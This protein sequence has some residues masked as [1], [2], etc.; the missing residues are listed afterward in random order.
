[1][2]NSNRSDS[3]AQIDVDDV[4]RRI[5]ETDRR[6]I[7][8][9]LGF[10]FE[11]ATNTADGFQKVLGP[12][13][14]GEGETPNFSVNLADG[15]FKDWGG[16]G[17]A[18]NL[19]HAVMEVERL[20]F[21]EAVAWV[22]DAI[23]MDTDASTYEGA[24]TGD[25]QP[26]APP[27]PPMPSKAST[28]VPQEDAEE[29]SPIEA[30]VSRSGGS[31]APLSAV[32]DRHNRLMEDEPAA[33]CAREYLMSRGIDRDTMQQAQLGLGKNRGSWQILVP[34]VDKL[35][36][37]P[38]VVAMKRLFFVPNR[39]RGGGDWERENGRKKMRN[40]GSAALIDH[41]PNPC[42]DGPVLVCEG[43]TDMLSALAHGFNAVAGTS[44]AGTF[45]KEWAAYIQKMQAADHGVIVAFD[46]DTAGRNGTPKAAQKLQ[47]QGIENVRI[48]RVPDGSDVND[49]VVKHGRSG[50]AALVDA[51]EPYAPDDPTDASTNADVSATEAAQ[52]PP[53]DEPMPYK[54][55][56]MD[57]LPEVVQGYVRAGAMAIDKKAPPAMVAV[58][59]L[60]VL[61]SAVGASAQIELKKGWQEGPTLWSVLVA[62]SGSTKSPA[63]HSAVKPVYGFEN[64]AQEAYERRMEE[65]RAIPEDERSEAE[66][67]TRDRYRIGDPTPEAVAKVLNENE[68]GVLL[69]R[70]ELAGWIGSFDRYS[71]GAA[72]AQFWIEIWG[73]TPISRDRASEGNITIAE[74]AV[75][76]SGTTQ[77]GTL[78][79][80]LGDVHFDT[81]FAQR[82]ILC[83]PPMPRKR[84][85]EAGID[86]PTRAAYERLLNDL[87]KLPAGTVCP[88]GRDAKRLWAQYYETENDIIY[89]LP[90]SAIRQVWAKGVTYVA[91]LALTLHLCRYVSGEVDSLEVDA[92]SMESAIRL[93]Q[94]LRRETVRVHELMGLR[95]AARD[96]IERFLDMLPDGTFKTADARAVASEEDVPHRT[97]YKWLN[98]L[99]DSSRVEKVKR[100]M[101]RKL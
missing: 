93:G 23:G 78:K 81:G 86:E 44:G 74:P 6:R 87:Y 15:L 61:A 18:G 34:A 24:S 98:R 35:Q 101:Y 9:Q 30:T 53:Q 33:E 62:P 79:G 40:L 88:I 58:P 27:T 8:E 60:P 55:F 95:S 96:P 10:S 25:T 57:T 92:Q 5:S 48:L 7:F 66:K 4:E 75:S 83:N 100:G 89:E 64:D 29:P 21:P 14:L 56:P 2:Q 16:S 82:L 42:N 77:P 32:V 51:A 76:V 84:W 73:R 52:E 65:W 1:M 39:E 67:P 43:E 20:D 71:N 11:R 90:E 70:D 3:S 91:R 13:A 22:A 45:H 17:A 94:W 49:V 38:V 85:T 97:M 47:A 31:V 50:L 26:T 59:S 28:E 12:K 72:D 80:K 37:P 63:F 68:R 19:Y 36:S 41:T 99:Q 69:A 46:G 54:P